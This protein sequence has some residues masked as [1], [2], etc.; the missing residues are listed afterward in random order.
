MDGSKKNYNPLIVCLQNEN[1]MYTHT[2]THTHTHI[3]QGFIQ[4]FLLGEENFFGRDDMMCIACH[5]SRGIWG[6][7]PHKEISGK[8]AVSRLILVGFGRYLTT[9]A[10]VYCLC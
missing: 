6:Y 9:T 8:L 1:G 7:S 5:P 2:H 4:D 3:H 10:L